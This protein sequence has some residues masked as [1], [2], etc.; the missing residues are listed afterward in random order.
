MARKRIMSEAEEITHECFEVNLSSRP[1]PFG[2]STV[3]EF[4][5]LKD[6]GGSGRFS[7]PWEPVKDREKY[8]GV[9]RRQASALGC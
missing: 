3:S 1:L 6:V 4:V 5:P 8:V 9:S 2:R 7:I